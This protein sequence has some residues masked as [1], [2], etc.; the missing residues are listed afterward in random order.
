MWGRRAERSSHAE[1]AADSCAERGLHPAKRLQASQRIP[2]NSCCLHY[3]S[4]AA[5]EIL[6]GHDVTGRN[7]LVR[8]EEV[9]AL[10]SSPPAAGGCRPLEVGSDLAGGGAVLGEG[11]AQR[12]LI[13][14]PPVRAEVVVVVVAVHVIQHFAWQLLKS[15]KQQVACFLA[16]DRGSPPIW[17]RRGSRR[18]SLHPSE[19]HI[20]T[21]T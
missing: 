17:R 16:L 12:C 15:A 20:S 10:P 18:L 11:V 13:E 6:G 3:Q 9:M 1:G 7:Y 8:E 19:W 4:C 5:T 21:G 14:A 2:C